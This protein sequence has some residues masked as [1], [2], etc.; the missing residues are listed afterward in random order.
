MMSDKESSHPRPRV[1]FTAMGPRRGRNGGVARERRRVVRG[2]D[3][4]LCDLWAHDR[5]AL[6]G[7]NLRSRHQDL[8][9]RRV[10]RA[11]PRLC[12]RRAR[13]RLPPAD[14]HRRNLRGP[15]GEMTAVDITPNA[16]RYPADAP[17]NDKETCGSV[18]SCCL[19]DW[20]SVMSMDS[21]SLSDGG[22][23]ARLVTRREV[24]P[25]A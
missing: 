23:L 18:R 8:L 3:A 25:I 15:D 1:R 4:A 19:A 10:P 13:S 22:I 17:R 12:A 21:V 14:E 6:P 24:A 16:V 2:A 7:G 20:E 9:Q 11:L 5:Q